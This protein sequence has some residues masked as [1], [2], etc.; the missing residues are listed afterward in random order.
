MVRLMSMQRRRGGKNNARFVS[1]TGQ[2]S[3]FVALIFQVLFVFFSMVVNIGLLVHDKVNLQN[4]VDMGA[5]YGAQRQAE[6]LNEIA[7]LNYQIR[8]DYKLLAWRYRVMGTL[9]RIANR[10]PSDP[11]VP[12]ARKSSGAGLTE[13]AYVHPS[14]GAG[15]FPSVCV[16]NDMWSDM[17]DNSP[18][19]ENYCWQPYDS[20]TP[21]IPD[22]V[23]IA[24]FVPMVGASAA[25][26][27]LA[28]QAQ[29]TACRE[30][31]PRNWAF[32]M[33][34]FYAYKL[35]V[36]SRK[37]LIWKLREHLV[38]NSTD[39][40]DQRGESIQQG[41]MQTITKNL[42][43]ANARTFNQEYFQVYN[44]LSH[45][46]CAAGGGEAF[47]PEIRTAPAMYYTLT[48]ARAGTG[49]FYSSL[50]HMQYQQIPGD[51]LNAWDPQSTYRGIANGESDPSDPYHSS[52][53]F[54]KNPWCMAYVGVRAKTKPHKP[55]APFGKEVEV[56]ARA[57][58]QPF[59]GRVGP[60]YKNK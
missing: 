18:E 43:E 46:G 51:L 25:F 47:L 57:Y 31:G 20:A 54:E 23:V 19:E 52:L 7:H 5:Y 10:D 59:G 2:M 28:Q 33:N 37:S 13:K 32:M 60:W 1:E 48:E 40:V 39:M 27:R 8:Q 55:F 45:Q 29:S 35:S 34:I 17:L 56:E 6:M 22:V 9:G 38:K 41:I 44:G 24:P 49:C 53:G 50:P 26:T 16:S 30:A 14:D 42:T 12:P 15:G 36:A 11:N 58:A 21:P 3:I 4:A